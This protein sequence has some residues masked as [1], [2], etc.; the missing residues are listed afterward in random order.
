MGTPLERRRSDDR[1]MQIERRR[2]FA[3]RSGGPARIST[4]GT[5][6]TAR[7]HIANAIQMF[8]QIGGEMQAEWA[9]V[10]DAAINRLNRA[11][12]ELESGRI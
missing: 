1:R 12:A 11:L 4:A 7:E 6:E 10:A 8:K 2:T 9:G 5:A 3:R